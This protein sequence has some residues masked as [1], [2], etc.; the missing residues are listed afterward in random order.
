MGLLC[1]K[2][3]HSMAYPIFNFEREDHDKPVIASGF[4]CAIVSDKSKS[5]AK[6]LNFQL[7]DWNFAAFQSIRCSQAVQ[8]A[9]PVL[10]SEAA[11]ES[12]MDQFNDS[13]V[14]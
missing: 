10:I 9:K 8:S 5:V 3:G 12:K 1:F 2:M 6:F 11:L 4:W 7:D 14:S 13:T